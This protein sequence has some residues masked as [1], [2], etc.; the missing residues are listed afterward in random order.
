M[1]PPVIPSPLLQAHWGPPRSS[2]Q[3][4]FTSGL[5]GWTASGPLPGPVAPCAPSGSQLFLSD[6]D[7]GSAQARNPLVIMCVVSSTAF[8]SGLPLLFPLLR[9]RRKVCC[10]R[11]AVELPVLFE[12]L[13]TICSASF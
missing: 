4:L 3:G 12:C 9:W 7:S 5:L 13:H 11:G 1:L 8:P 10:S 2:I 6:A